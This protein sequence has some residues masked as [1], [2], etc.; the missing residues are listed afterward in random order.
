[1]GRLGD[2]KRSLKRRLLDE[3]DVIRIARMRRGEILKF[4]DPRRTAIFSRISLTSEQQQ[5]I[6]E[7]YLKN[8]GSKIPHTWHRHFTA[9]TGN[10]D[11]RYFPELLYI[12]EFEYFMNSSKDYITAFSDKNVLPMIARSA[13]IKTP[14]VIFSRTC[15]IFRDSDN[16]FITEQDAFNLLSHSGE[17]F[18]KPS[19]DSC[20]GMGCEVINTSSQEESRSLFTRLGTDFVIQERLKCHADLAAIYP[21]SVNT[22]RVISYIWHGKV[23]ICPVILRIGQGGKF[24]DNA[25]AG[26]IFIAVN[27][28]GSLHKTAFT[29]FNTQ[30]TGH[31]DTGLK[32][33]GWKINN[34]PKIINAAKIMHEAV[35]QIGVV[36]WDFTIGQDGEPI[37]MEG[38]M[39]SGSIWLIEMAHGKGVFGDDTAEILQWTR[40]M[41]SLKLSERSHYRFGNI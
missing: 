9:F 15:S 38:N 40:K 29:E 17:V 18:A 28:D 32:F 36:N 11:Y 6:N 14:R 25:H 33:E 37:L 22:F 7:F 27:N 30:F 23:K 4:Q 3:L 41:K 24:L 5:Q 13:G 12:P 1:M 21:C 8:Y 39:R 20:S 26:G 35:P 10:F 19:V 31:P 2:I 34:F 16:R